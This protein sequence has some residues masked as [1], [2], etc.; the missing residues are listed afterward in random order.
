[1]LDNVLS[2]N[3]IQLKFKNKMNKKEYL[4]YVIIMIKLLKMKNYF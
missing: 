2:Y 1:M 3:K 4:L